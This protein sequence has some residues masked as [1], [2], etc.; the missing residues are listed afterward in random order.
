MTN[1]TANVTRPT[2]GK[3]DHQRYGLVGY[4]DYQGGNTA[5]TTYKGEPMMLDVS[6]VDGYA[7]PFKAVAAAVNTD[8]FLGFAVEQVAITSA[9]TANGAKDILVQTDGLVGV[10]L[11]SLTV[12]D[13][14]AKIY[15]SDSNTFTTTATNALWVGTLANVDA[16]YAWIDLRLSAGQVS[17]T[18]S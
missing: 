3:V 7:Q 1:L 18:T 2:K 14:G 15:A 10:P 6:D 17:A 11:G 8:V 4:T 12:T 13:I 5:Y 16:N 9:N